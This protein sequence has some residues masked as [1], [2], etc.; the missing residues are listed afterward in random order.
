MFIA[1]FSKE[2]QEKFLNLAYT[3]VYADG[4]LDQREQ[5]IFIGYSVEFGGNGNR[6]YCLKSGGENSGNRGDGSSCGP[7]SGDSR[8]GSSCGVGGSLGCRRDNRLATRKTRI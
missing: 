8:L 1:G 5:Q 2:K 7:F 3:M 4:R 6:S